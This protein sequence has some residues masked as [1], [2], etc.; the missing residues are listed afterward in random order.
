M[1][2]QTSTTHREGEGTGPYDG[3]MRSGRVVEGAAGGAPG[4]PGLVG[5]VAGDATAGVVVWRRG[6]GSTLVEAGAPNASRG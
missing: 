6:R 2:V 3:E 4:P 1:S 5:N